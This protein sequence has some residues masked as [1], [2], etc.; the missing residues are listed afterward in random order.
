MPRSAPVICG[1]RPRSRSCQVS[2]SQGAADPPDLRTTTD[3]GDQIRDSGVDCP[4][5][6]VNLSAGLLLHDKL[7]KHNAIHAVITLM[8]IWAISS[9]NALT[10]HNSELQAIQNRVDYSTVDHNLIS[11]VFTTNI[12]TR[13]VT[14][15]TGSGQY[16]TVWA[17][18]QSGSAQK[19]Q[20][21]RVNCRN[22]KVQYIEEDGVRRGGDFWA[23]EDSGMPQYACS[24]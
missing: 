19:D 22:L 14:K 8:A 5:K 20:I 23:G 1:T 11:Q 6:P 10:A 12:Y 13:R 7:N 21:I 3:Q 4:E 17:I 2:P 18:W 9:A 15:I 16:R 24:R